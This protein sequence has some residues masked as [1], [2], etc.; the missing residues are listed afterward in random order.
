MVR[1][2]LIEGYLLFVKVLFSICKLFPLQKKV[3]FITS[4]GDNCQFILD[5]MNKQQLPIQ[6]VIL[7]KSGSTMHTEDDGQ[8][9]V[10][11]FETKNLIQMLCSIYHLATSKWVIV[12]N[13]FGILAAVTF[14]Q[15]V[16]CIQVWHAVGAVKQFGLR[17]PSIESRSARAKKRFLDVYQN[18]HYVVT[19]S[20][21]MSQIFKDSFQLTN[22]QIL[23]TG[24]PR[25]DFFFDGE[26]KMLAEETFY[27]EFPELENKKIIL[28]APTFR[29]DAL[30]TAEIA[31]DLDLLYKEL[32]REDYVLIL[33]LHP[34]VTMKHNYQQQYPG[35]IYQMDADFHVNEILLVADLLITDYSS[36]PYEFSFLNKPMLFFAYDLAQYTQQR[37]FWEDYEAATPGPIVKTT[38]ELVEKIHAADFCLEKVAPFN[39]KWNEYSNG[40][41][42][43]KLVTFLF[44]E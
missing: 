20:E 34:A 27:R 33:K 4:F 17:D 24:V 30:Q 32:F 1:E 43:E 8:T 22:Q 3:T 11:P 15:E 40:Q 5:E 7:Q 41:S 12:D 42:S 6:K 10:F 36:I 26:A 37:G 16:T 31:L 28:Y 39:R 23:R 25:T 2:G 35:F 44:K 29:D 13:Y 21:A 38:E 18:F 9:I 19:G 14:K